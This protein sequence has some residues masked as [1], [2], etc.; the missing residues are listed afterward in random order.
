[1]RF[2]PGQSGNPKG[3]PPG[4]V[5]KFKREAQAANALMS[6]NVVPATKRLVELALGAHLLM[7][8]DAENRE[9]RAPKSLG[10]AKAHLKAGGLYRVYVDAPDL[11]AIVVVQDRA[12]GKVPAAVNIEIKQVVEDAIETQAALVRIIEERVPPQY[13]AAIRDDLRRIRS[14]AARSRATLDAADSFLPPADL[15]A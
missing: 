3:R 6:Q 12:L 15:P 14:V 4:V 8:F 2:Q 10:E 13:L 1:M 5:G 11:R 7:L 9:W